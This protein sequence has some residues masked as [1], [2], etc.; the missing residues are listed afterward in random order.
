VETRGLSNSKALRV[1]WLMPDVGSGKDRGYQA[2]RSEEITGFSIQDE[3]LK[4]PE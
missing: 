2:H 3:R 1:L 4:S